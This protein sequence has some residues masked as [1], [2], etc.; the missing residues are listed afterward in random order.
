MTST[1]P[2]RPTTARRALRLTGMAD[3]SMPPCPVCGAD[4]TGVT[5]D[6]SDEVTVY[7]CSAC[8]ASWAVR[9]GA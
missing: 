4:R 6:V 9:A 1:T 2:G 3:T 7:G 5:E 8:D